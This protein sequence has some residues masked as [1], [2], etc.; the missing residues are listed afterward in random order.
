MYTIYVYIFLS[1][2][3]PPSPS[4]SPSSSPSPSLLLF[5]LCVFLAL[6]RSLSLARPLFPRSTSLNVI[7]AQLA[8]QGR[9]M[10]QSP[11]SEGCDSR[12]HTGA[13]VGTDSV[14]RL[15]TKFRTASLP[16]HAKAPSTSQLSTEGAQKPALVG[17]AVWVIDSPSFFPPAAS[18][19]G[20]CLLRGHDISVVTT[21]FFT[22]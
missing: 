7:F 17:G 15:R 21:V 4:P 10:E 1:L 6:S 2:S 16:T 14:G 12:G 9:T 18:H 3:L 8:P 22:L 19:S 13:P 20:P 5:C 11:V